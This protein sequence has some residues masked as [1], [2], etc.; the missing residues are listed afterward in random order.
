MT[1]SHN[2]KS[3]E[4]QK[5]QDCQEVPFCCHDFLTFLIARETEYQI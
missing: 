3:Q 4:R 1:N 2:A 5:R